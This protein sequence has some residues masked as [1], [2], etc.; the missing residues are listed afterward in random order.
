[1]RMSLSNSYA[2]NVTPKA[3]VVGGGAFGRSLH[4][5]GTLMNVVSVFIK[6]APDSALALSAC[7]DTEKAEVCNPEE[8]F[9]QTQP[10]PTSCH[11]MLAS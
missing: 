9:H 3:V 1:M 7:E 4:E 5:G 8:G 10:P 6:E 2:E 11:T